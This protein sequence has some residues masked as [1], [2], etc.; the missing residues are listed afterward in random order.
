MRLRIRYTKQGKVR[1]ISHRDTARAWERAIRRAQ[2]PIVYTEGFSP[3]P[4]MHFGLALS[5]GHE[6]DAEYIDIDLDVQAD[7]S[8]P[9]LQLDTLPERLSAVLPDGIR[10][11]ACGSVERGAPS[12]QAAVTHCTWQ[13][14]FSTS[15]DVLRQRVDQILAA[16]QLPLRRVRKGRER[17]DD[18]RPAILAVEIDERDSSGG[19]LHVELATQPRSLRPAEFIELLT[20]PDEPVDEVRVRTRSPMDRVH[21]RPT[22]SARVPALRGRDRRR[23]RPCDMDRGTHRCVRHEEGTSPCPNPRGWTASPNSPIVTSRGDRRAATPLRR[24]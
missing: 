15:P 4:K 17:V 16:D 18:A 20:L 9:V 23:P 7:A 24:R 11:T 6:S 2:L 13:M 22:S 3:R 12:L 10:A 14:I 1:F 21:W 19:T 8:A 5:N